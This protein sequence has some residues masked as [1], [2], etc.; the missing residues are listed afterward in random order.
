[1]AGS[2]KHRAEIFLEI[3]CKPLSL[4]LTLYLLFA[5]DLL[6]HAKENVDL[7]LEFIGCIMKFFGN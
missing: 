4:M 1:M 7:I 2:S 6:Q 5:V 3:F